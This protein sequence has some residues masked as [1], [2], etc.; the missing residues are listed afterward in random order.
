M[1][2]AHDGNAWPMNS[3][4]SLQ[5]PGQRQHCERLWIN[6]RFLVIT[7]PEPNK[8]VCL[9]LPESKLQVLGIS[10]LQADG[11]FAIVHPQ[12]AMLLQ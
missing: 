5:L 7:S 9:R 1:L 12:L 4:Q 11:P 2:K 8:A 6:A 10:I 3:W